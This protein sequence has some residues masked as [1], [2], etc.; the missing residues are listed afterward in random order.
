MPMP[1]PEEFFPHV[2]GEEPL[3]RRFPKCT[4]GSRRRLRRPLPARAGRRPF[5][6][7]LSTN[8]IAHFMHFSGYRGSGFVARRRREK[9]ANP[10]ANSDPRRKKKSVAEHLAI[11]AANRSGRP[12]HSLSCH[13]VSFLGSVAQILEGLGGVVSH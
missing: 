13:F 10:D 12:R 6:G 4:V 2:V 11:L 7:K 1:W 8:F 9:Q 5:R 3:K